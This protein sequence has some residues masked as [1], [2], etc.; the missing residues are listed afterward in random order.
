MT[1][2]QDSER[3]AVLLSTAEIAKVIPHRWPFLL[4]DR[5]LEG[6]KDGGAEVEK[7]YL[8]GLNIQECD[9][10]HVCWQ[11][12]ECSKNDDMNNLY[13]RIIDSDVIVFGTQQ[14]EV[15]GVRLVGEVEDVADD[16]DR[17]EQPVDRD[18]PRHLRE[19]ALAAADPPRFH[20]EPARQRR[21]HRVADARHEA[22][23]A[24]QTEAEVRARQPEAAVEPVFQRIEMG[25]TAGR[26][27][28]AGA[29]R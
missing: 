22:D 20:H 1:D 2:A 27:P 9:G 10:C 26:R 15:L 14:P 5:I 12:N 6:A 29:I 28:V 17:A 23:H 8:K 19:D 18:I 16:R 25:E 24:V 11:G 13:P 4:V 3:P 7:V 21:R